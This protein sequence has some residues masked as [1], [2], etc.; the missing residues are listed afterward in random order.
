[1]KTLFSFVAV[2]VLI[3]LAYA[4]V[5]S[6]GMQ[7]LFGVVIPYVAVFIFIA[8]FIRKILVWASVPVPFCIPTTCGQ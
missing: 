4:G 6:A 5:K 7:Y 8:G 3:L 2:A 1:M